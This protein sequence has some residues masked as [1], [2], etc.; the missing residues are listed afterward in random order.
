[1]RV[2]RDSHRHN[3]FMD[4][5]MKVKFFFGV[6]ITLALLWHI[7]RRGRVLGVPKSKFA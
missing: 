2:G 4:I 7:F 6:I 5:L 3:I 1:M